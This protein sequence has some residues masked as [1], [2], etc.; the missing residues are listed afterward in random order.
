MNATMNGFARATPKRR[1][2]PKVGKEAAALPPKPDHLHRHALAGV[3]LMA[4]MSG[5]LNGYAHS[6]HAT[7]TWAGWVLG[8]LIP[9]IILILGKVAGT[10]W[11]RGRTKLAHVTAGAGVGLLTL[12][13]WHCTTS[14][15]LLTGSPLLLAAPMAVAIDLGFVCCELA[16]L[17]PRKEG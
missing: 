13:V 5:G 16:L 15:A 4:V 9:A 7:V 1:A 10:L 6:L 17:E 11:H 3:V 8:L 2:S 12:S 14:I